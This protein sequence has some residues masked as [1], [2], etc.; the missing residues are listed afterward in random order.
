MRRER[1]EDVLVDRGILDRRVGEDDR[2]R[3]LPLL[4]IG[5]HV[6]DHVACSRRS[7][8][9]RARR[10]S[11]RHRRRSAGA[12]SAAAASSGERRARCESWSWRSSCE[13]A[14]DA[15]GELSC[16]SRRMQ[17][18][19]RT[20]CSTAALPAAARPA[21]TRL[22]YHPASAHDVP[23][24]LNVV[25]PRR[26]AGQAH[27]FGAAEGAAPARRPA[28]ASRTCSTPRAR[29][30]RARSRSSSATAATPCRRRSPRRTSRSCTQDPPR[31]TGDATRVA[32]AALP[33]DGVTLVT[34][35]DMPAGAAGG[36]GR[37]RRASAAAGKLAVLTAHVPDPIGLGRIVRDARGDGARDR[38]GAAT[39]RRRSARSTRSTPA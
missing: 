14:R 32:L 19:R 37:A 21:R 26:R 18:H 3:V 6:G 17:R 31:G 34:I 33:A 38:R 10:D 4:R 13:W 11:C 24:P 39:R 7:T 12:A 35:G 8:S 5:R 16:G 9:R 30:R 2:R 25:D 23:P 29:L 1:L 27:A 15:R 20:D 36:A 22:A 28:A